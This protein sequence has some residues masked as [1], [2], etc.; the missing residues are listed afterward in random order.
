M[1]DFKKVRQWI[2][3]SQIGMANR[4]GIKQGSYSGIERG[5]DSASERLIERALDK[6]TPTVLFVSHS[7]RTPSIVS[8]ML[9]VSQIDCIEH[10]PEDF[11]D[12]LKHGL[13]IAVITDDKEPFL[14][15]IK[16]ALDESGLPN[17]PMLG[18][19]IDSAGKVE[20]WND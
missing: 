4:L 3:L 14:A 7:E 2:G 11:N 12:A 10:E 13:R 1:I 16:Q 20:P 18:I 6:V 8:A 19:K 17:I 9:S 15:L 5:K